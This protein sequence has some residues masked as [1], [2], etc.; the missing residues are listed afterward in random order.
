VDPVELA[1][2]QATQ[3]AL[4]A[5]RVDMILSDFLWVANQRANGA[6]WTFAPFSSAIGALIAPPDSP[7][8]SVADLK[9][10]RLG[11]AGSPL[12]KSWLILRA[13]GRRTLGLDLDQAA[14]KSFGAPPL[15][16]QQLAAG[17]LDAILTYWPFAAKAEA[18]GMRRV[19]GVAQMVRALGIPADVPF[20]GY[21][22]SAAWAERNREAVDGF[23]AAGR[24]AQALLVKSDEEWLRLKPLT[25]AA[26]DAELEQLKAAY[27]AGVPG[28]WGEAERNAAGLLYTILA[29]IGG[30][31]L[32]G[33]SPIL[34]AGTFWQA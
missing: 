5:G 8:K 9:G 14:N 32:V 2:S 16:S 10:A 12:D 6:D 7:V 29:E 25:G 31:A 26:D 4:Q 20:V 15:L 18:A 27:R 11:V 34:P 1:A 17:Q 22:F 23:L 28:Q 21:V 30:A 33:P 3:V 19:I 24:D 13:Y